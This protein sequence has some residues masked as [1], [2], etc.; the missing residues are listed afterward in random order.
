MVALFVILTVVVCIAVDSLIQ[1]R[2]ALKEAREATPATAQATAYAFD[3]LSVPA[4]VY[5]DGGHTW[6]HLEADGDAHVG[7]DRFAESL[8]GRV[9][10]VELPEVGRE[11]HR[12]ERL[13]SLVQGERVTDFV[14][15]IDGVVRSVAKTLGR[16]PEAIKSDPY[17]EGWVCRLVPR[18]LARNLKR[19]RIAEEARDWLAGEAARFQEFFAAR[20]LA[21]SPLGAVMQD[22]GQPTGGVLEWMDDETWRRFNDEFLHKPQN[23]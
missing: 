22:G 1:W 2:R 18:N 14:A 15:P 4:G 20:P 19:L 23:N 6:V 13:F 3:D 16:H 10:A 5:L 21:E 9:D 8:L 7:V 11:V 12:G 17:R